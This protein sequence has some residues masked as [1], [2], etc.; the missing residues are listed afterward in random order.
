MKPSIKAIIQVF[1]KFIINFHKF[2]DEDV[3]DD[4]RHKT[5]LIN[6]EKQ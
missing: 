5:Q 3:Q 6:Q 1:N 2:I 4:I